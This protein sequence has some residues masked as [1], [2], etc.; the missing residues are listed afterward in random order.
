[1][2]YLDKYN[3]KKLSFIEKYANFVLDYHKYQHKLKNKNHL[4]IN[5][6]KFI[7]NPNEY[8]KLLEKKIW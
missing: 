4:L 6:E 8:I 1:M 7:I 2:W 5:Y 3:G